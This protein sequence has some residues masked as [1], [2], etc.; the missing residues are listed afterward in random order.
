MLLTYFQQDLEITGKQIIDVKPNYKYGIED[1][2]VYT[3]KIQSTNLFIPKRGFFR[4]TECF[5]DSNGVGY[6]GW[7]FGPGGNNC[8]TDSTGYETCNHLEC[9]NKVCFRVAGFGNNTCDNVG[10][11]C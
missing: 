1:G 11:K 6:C 7:A 2:G 10:T 8:W 9:I 5:V 4:H 3:E